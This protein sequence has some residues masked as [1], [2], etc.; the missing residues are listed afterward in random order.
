LALTIVKKGTGS[1]VF[2]HNI[3]KEVFD[4]FSRKHYSKYKEMEAILRGEKVPSTVIDNRGV[5]GRWNPIDSGV[6]QDVNQYRKDL[7]VN[8]RHYE[9]GHP[10]RLT[11]SVKNALYRKALRLKQQIIVG[12]LPQDELHPIKYRPKA[13]GKLEPVVDYE[14]LKQTKTVERNIAWYDKNEVNL[15]EF[16]RI[17]R[18]L[19]PD[20]KGITKIVENWRPKT[21]VKGGKR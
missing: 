11:P 13:N 8:K 21:K 18:V 6:I 16:K 20:D 9:K 15:R 5:R 17:M 7:E 2:N 10:I 3:T 14:K 19:E 1:A 12:M 4:P